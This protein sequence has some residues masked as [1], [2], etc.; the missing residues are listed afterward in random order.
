MAGSLFISNFNTMKSFLI[1]L[2]LFVILF[3]ASDYLLG[4]AIRHFHS[5]TENTNLANTNYGFLNYDKEEILFFGASE[6]SHSFISNKVTRESGFSTYNLASD[7]CGIFYQYALLETILEKH[8]PKAILISSSQL[9]DDGTDYLT[10]LYPYYRNNFHVRNVIDYVYPNEYFKLALQGYAFNSQIIRIFDSKDDNSNGYIKI[11][12]E[13]STRVNL[14]DTELKRG[15]NY[16]M[17]KE[18]KEYFTKF[19]ELATSKGIVVYIFVP[20]VLETIDE[21]YFNE[22]VS[23]TANTEVKLLDFSKDSTLLNHR[24]LFYDIT[25][26][27]H[28]G[29]IIM[30]DKF[31]EILKNDTI[32]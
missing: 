6:V 21:E 25:H 28:E 8:I 7:G 11:P 2:L 16:A 3:F 31:I 15:L 20:P 13:E 4:L 26:L 14:E 27:N 23:L 32:N 19:I 10:R 12:A 5:K 1:K 29:A 24:E 17:S 18:T 22:I 30:T 9:N